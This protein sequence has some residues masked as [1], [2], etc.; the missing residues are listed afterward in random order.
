MSYD[1]YVLPFI[2]NYSIDSSKTSESR[3]SRRDAYVEALLKFREERREENGLKIE[4]LQEEARSYEKLEAEWRDKLKYFKKQLG[5]HCEGTKE[6]DMFK[7]L[8]LKARFSITSCSN[9][10]YSKFLQA[11]IVATDTTWF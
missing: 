2:K 5:L 7:D 9:Q 11:F 3:T 10:A 6:Y 4:Q 8:C 1:D